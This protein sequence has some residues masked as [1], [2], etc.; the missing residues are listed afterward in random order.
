MPLRL[1]LTSDNGEILIAMEMTL[2]LGLK[3]KMMCELPYSQCRWQR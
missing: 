1:V 2:N 3:E